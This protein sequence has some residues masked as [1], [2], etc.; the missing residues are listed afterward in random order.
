MKCYACNKKLIEKDDNY[1]S[2][3]HIDETCEEHRVSQY[4]QE[5]NENLIRRI[6]KLESQRDDLQDK[7]SDLEHELECMKNNG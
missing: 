3:C 2:S 5:E 7:I 1:C 6:Y 4:Y